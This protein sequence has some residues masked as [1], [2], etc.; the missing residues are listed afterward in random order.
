MS[1]ACDIIAVIRLLSKTTGELNMKEISS[2][3]CIA[4]C[5]IALI[6]FLLPAI[7]ISIDFFGISRTVT[8]SMASFFDRPDNPFG[9]LDI[10]NLSQI[11]IFDMSDDMFEE[12]S[13]KIVTA[14]GAYFITSILLIVLLI[15]MIAGKL[16]KAGIILSAASLVLFIYAGYTITTVVESLLARLQ[17]SIEAALGFF[18][19]V[20]DISYILTLSLGNGFW[21]TLTAIGGIVLVNIISF[22]KLSRHLRQK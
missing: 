3:V 18:A 7:N 11:N 5:V 17:S 19:M 9:D 10:S 12:V 14:V 16:K 15:C 8:L 13:A 22:I 20:I 6:G 1:R 4:L 21:L 2:R